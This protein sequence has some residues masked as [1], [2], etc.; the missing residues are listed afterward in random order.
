[1]LLQKFET[2]K[3]RKLSSHIL[4]LM[5][6]DGID[7][8]NLSETPWSDLHGKER[9]DTFF[10]LLHMAKEKTIAIIDG[11]QT[12]DIEKLTRDEPFV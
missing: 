3:P 2:G 5:E 6:D 9:R 4:P 10:G 7:Y 12:E 1:M 8:A 11:F